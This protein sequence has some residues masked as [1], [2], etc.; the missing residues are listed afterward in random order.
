MKKLSKNSTLLYDLTQFNTKRVNYSQKFIRIRT[1][2]SLLQ[3]EMTKRNMLNFIF[4]LFL[5]SN[6]R[7]RLQ[8]ALSGDAVLKIRKGSLIGA[9]IDI[10]KFDNI[11]KL[12]ILNGSKNDFFRRLL[13][14]LPKN[15]TKQAFSVSETIKIIPNSYTFRLMSGVE[16]FRIVIT[17]RFGVSCKKRRQFIVSQ[18]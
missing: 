10:S 13:F 15:E 7:P 8:T 5:V 2:I 18:Y 16:S 4:F 3:K 17:T 14:K 9:Y 11:E 12:F 6:L 1:S